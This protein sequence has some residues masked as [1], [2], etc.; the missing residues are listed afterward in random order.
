[1]HFISPYCAITNSPL[2]IFETNSFHND[3]ARVADSIDFRCSD[4]NRK[5]FVFGLW[6]PCFISPNT[7][8]IVAN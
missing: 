5:L 8:Q 6:S 4:F 7:L 2:P 1:M 3:Q